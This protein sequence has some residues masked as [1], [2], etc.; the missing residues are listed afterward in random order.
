MQGIKSSGIRRMFELAS[1][2]ESPLNLSIG[3]ADFDVPD[4]IKDAAIKAI[5]DGKNGYTVTQGIPELNER[6]HADLKSRY[7]YDADATLVTSG[8]SGGLLLAFMVILD[9]GDE[10]LIPDPYFV[11]YKNLALL[12]GAVP[13]Y[14]NT[15]PDFRLTREA[16]EAAVS[17]QTKVLL[18]NSPGNPTGV[19]RSEEELQLAVDFA[20][21][22]DLILISDEIYDHFIYDQPFR[23]LCEFTNDVILVSGFSKS[24][25]MAGW[26]IG[27]A[28]G[29]ADIL[30][31]MKTLQ[32]FSF[33]CAPAPAQHAVVA[34]F[35]VD[36][37]P[38]Y[39]S[40]RDKR[41]LVFEGIKNHFEVVKPEGSFYMFP[42]V[43]GLLSDMEFVEQALAENLLIVPGS[44]CSEQG[45]HFR[46]S[47]AAS[48]DILQAGVETLNRMASAVKAGDLK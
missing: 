22:H 46:L 1:S 8:V 35:D 5:R 43:P 28:T 16:L 14:Y 44:T 25:G 11:M 40:Y 18:V 31:C 41:D 2:L 30:D 9:A 29:P 42:K 21:E 32:Q 19:V 15:Y 13:R 7:R 10:V 37:S 45:S 34:A 3:Q 36:L 20:R 24:L 38:Y 47:F 23:S 33:V 27:Y 48:N 4:P 39:K 26:R 17:E 12:A 6:I